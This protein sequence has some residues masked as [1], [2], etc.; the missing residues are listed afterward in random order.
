MLSLYFLE[1]FTR[2]R[3]HILGHGAAREEEDMLQHGRRQEQGPVIV[4]RYARTTPMPTPDPRERGHAV[5]APTAALQPPPGNPTR[6]SNPV[7]PETAAAIPSRHVTR[8]RD[9]APGGLNCVSIPGDLPHV[10]AKRAGGRSRSADR[11]RSRSG[12][13]PRSL[14]DVAHGSETFLPDSQRDRWDLRS[15]ADGA[16]RPPARR[17][18]SYRLPSAS[19][20]AQ[21]LQVRRQASSIFSASSCAPC[22]G[23]RARGKRF[24]APSTVLALPGRHLHVNLFRSPRRR[25]GRWRAP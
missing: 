7:S 17:P 11:G 23:R 20:G 10:V 13:D 18:A 14:A 15:G 21:P 2:P 24:E 5:A 16:L 8:D 4:P 3:E 9:V 1:I 12:S 6:S 19:K 22:A 25:Y